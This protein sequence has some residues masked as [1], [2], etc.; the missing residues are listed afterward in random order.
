[1]QKILH[2]AIDPGING[3][4]AVRYLDGEFVVFPFISD[5][6]FVRVMAELAKYCVAEGCAG[7]IV[8]EKVGGF[9]GKAQPGSSMFKFGDNNGFIRGVCMALGFS[10]RLVAPVTW[11]KPYPKAK[12]KQDGTRDKAQHKRDLRDI[13][14]RL[15]PQFRVTLK[16]ADAL[17][18]LDYAITHTSAQ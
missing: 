7:R 8:I 16:N 12:V 15:F 2:I 1:M 11:Q 9:V 17:L 6:E 13:A 10:V 4:V 18:L 5:D 14:A 3:A